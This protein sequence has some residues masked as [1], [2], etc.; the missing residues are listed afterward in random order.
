MID[1]CECMNLH[2]F[3]MRIVT[4]RGEMNLTETLQEKKKQIQPLWVDRT[5][6]SY[7][8]SGFFKKSLELTTLNFLNT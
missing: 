1:D 7:A 4:D 3:F 5:L 6:D 8:S 2:S